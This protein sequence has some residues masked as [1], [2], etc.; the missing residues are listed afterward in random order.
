LRVSNNQQSDKFK[1]TTIPLSPSRNRIAKG[2]ADT[3]HYG[4][5]YNQVHLHEGEFLHNK[6]FQG[7]SMQITVLDA[8]F[9]QYKNI[10]AFDSIRLNG[11]VLG[12][13]DFVTF[14]NSVNEDD[15]H[16]MYCLSI[17]AANWP[18]KNGR[19]GSESKLLARS[20]R[21]CFI[22]ISN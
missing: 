7:Q 2:T 22:R 14:D 9:F 13:R 8:G 15:S 19:Y 6:G 20:N 16:G 18:G 17:L 10:N 3:L 11:Q 1:E 21:E 4:N 5:S 12:E